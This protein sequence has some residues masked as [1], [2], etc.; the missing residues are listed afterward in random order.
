[1]LRRQKHVLSQSTTPFACTLFSHPMIS[2]IETSAKFSVH[3]IWVANPHP[4]GRG[5]MWGNCRNS[6]EKSSKLPFSPPPLG[7]LK[8]QIL[9]TENFVDVSISHPMIA[10]APNH[11]PHIANRIGGAFFCQR[12]VGAHASGLVFASCVRTLL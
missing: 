5:Q 4:T 2:E 6:L 7:G 11:L 1:M 9:W 8:T 12:E 3:K 10:Q